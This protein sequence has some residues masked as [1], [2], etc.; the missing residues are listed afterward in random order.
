MPASDLA[1]LARMDQW[2]A[3]LDEL[4][5]RTASHLKHCPQPELC[6]PGARVS[7][8]I[9]GFTT[10]QLTTLLELAL[11]RLARGGDRHAW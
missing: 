10:D 8:A 1:L 6:C 4:T 2:N 7:E 5:A 3:S 11:V 9:H